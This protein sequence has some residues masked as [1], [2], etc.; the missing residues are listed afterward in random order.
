MDQV[1]VK[2][3]QQQLIAQ[4]TQLKQHV[5]IHLSVLIKEE[6]VLNS[7]E[8][9]QIIQQQLLVDVHSNPQNVLKE[10]WLVE[11]IH[12]YLLL[13][14]A[15]LNNLLIHAMENS[16]MME[17][18]VTTLH[19]LALHMICQNV[20]QEQFKI[21]VLEDVF[22]PIM[23]VLLKHVLQ[24]LTQLN[25]PQSIVMIHL[26]S[27]FVPSQEQLVPMLLMPLV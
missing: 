15:L 11:L 8:H 2:L 17:K 25:V 20:Q 16:K 6:L 19:Q 13:L 14:H 10:H 23:H 7:Q 5:T 18:Y 4:H 1:H 22:G 9:V 27:Q 21:C 26:Q 12:V 3:L 24:S